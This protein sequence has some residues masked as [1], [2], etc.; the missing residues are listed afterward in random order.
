MDVAAFFERAIPVTISNLH[1]E[2]PNG[3]LHMLFS[4]SDIQSPSQLHPLFFGCFDWHSSVHCHWQLL[5]ALHLFPNATFAEAARSALAQSFTAENVAGEMNYLTNRPGFE[6]PYGMAWL[7]QLMVELRQTN[8]DPFA[9]W[10]ATLAPLEA[11][12]ANAFRR[13]LARMSFPVRGGL[14]NQSAF[15]LGLAYDWAMVAGDQGLSELI[16]QRSLDFYLGDFD[17]PLAYEPSSTDFLSPALA[18][19]DLLRR[20]LSPVE[21]ADWLWHFLGHDALETLPIRLAPVRVASFTDGQLAHFAGLNLSRA[22]MLE[23]IH[24]GLPADDPRRPMLLDL[25]V[26][27]REAGLPDALHEDYMVSHWAPTFAAYLLTGRGRN[28]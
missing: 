20:L 24:A 17:A 12:A 14:H 4:A 11:H 25:A 27:H 5:R 10:Q 9:Q 28:R 18:E 15:S 21:F 22:W 16:R 26:R 8:G 2:Y 3:I 13:Y 1:R 23:G 6:L 19:A 7:L